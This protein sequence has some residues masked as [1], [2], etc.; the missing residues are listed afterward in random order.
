MEGNDMKTHV[1]ETDDLRHQ[2]EALLA[3]LQRRSDTRGRLA[4]KCSD[5]SFAFLAPEEIRWVDALRNYVRV[6]SDDRE[7]LVRQPIHEFADRLDGQLG[8]AG[9]VVGIV[10]HCLALM[11]EDFLAPGLDFQGRGHVTKR[12]DGTN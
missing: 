2:L 8:A 3:E 1:T 5:G 10:F 9:A 6:N 11:K 7:Y 4:L 12:K